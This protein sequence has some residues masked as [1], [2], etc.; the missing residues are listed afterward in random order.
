[1]QLNKSPNNTSI[2]GIQQQP[3]NNSF[4]ARIWA[5]GMLVRQAGA[6]LWCLVPHRGSSCRSVGEQESPSQPPF[7]PLLCPALPPGQSPAPGWAG[8]SR[9]SWILCRCRGCF[10]TKGHL[11]PFP[12]RKGSARARLPLSSGINYSP[13]GLSWLALTNSCP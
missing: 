9:F 7:P 3:S 1:M 8:S 11:L 12:C 5:W 2:A 13:W 4:S 6:A 10:C